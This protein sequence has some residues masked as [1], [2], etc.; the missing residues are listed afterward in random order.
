M[1]PV[2]AV[3]SAEDLQPHQIYDLIVHYRKS[4]NVEKNVKYLTLAAKSAYSHNHVDSAH[5]LL[6]ELVKIGSNGRQ[7]SD[8]ML[9]A[10]TERNEVAPVVTTES[11]S[12]VGTKEKFR[13]LASLSLT[14]D[15]NL[16]SPEKFFKSPS[17]LSPSF[18]TPTTGSSR[19]SAG[20]RT[21]SVLSPDDHAANSRLTAQHSLMSSSPRHSKSMSDPAVYSRNGPRFSP[22]MDTNRSPKLK[23]QLNIRNLPSDLDPYYK[24]KK[25]VVISDLKNKYEANS[26]YICEQAAAENV[27]LLALLTFR[28]G[29]LQLAHNLCLLFIDK[30]SLPMVDL[31]T[32]NSENLDLETMRKLRANSS[33]FNAEAVASLVLDSPVKGQAPNFQSGPMM[34]PI[35]EG[36]TNS[37]SNDGMDDSSSPVSKASNTAKKSKQSLG[38]LKR[39]LMFG[40]KATSELDSFRFSRED[41]G[42]S[43]QSTDSRWK[44]S[45]AVEG[46]PPTPPRPAFVSNIHIS[47][48]RQL[49]ATNPLLFTTYWKAVDRLILVSLMRGHLAVAE[50]LY[51]IFAEQKSNLLSGDSVAEKSSTP[52]STKYSGNSSGER[53]MS[54]I[55]HL[56]TVTLQGNFDGI[57]LKATLSTLLLLAGQ[58]HDARKLIDNAM[59]AVD[60]TQDQYAWASCLF[61]RSLHSASTCDFYDARVDLIGASTSFTVVSDSNNS[62]ASLL[63]RAWCGVL[64]GDGLHEV[65]FFLKSMEGKIAS[66]V[67]I[68]QKNVFLRRSLDADRFRGSALGD[69]VETPKTSPMHREPGTSFTFENTTKSSRRHSVE[70]TASTN[71]NRPSTRMSVK[72][73]DMS[74]ALERLR[75]TASETAHLSTGDA[76]DYG[77]DDGEPVKSP[78]PTP[79]KPGKAPRFT[80]SDRKVQ[81][82]S[83]DVAGGVDIPGGGSLPSH[84]IQWISD[85]AL[86]RCFM[87]RDYNGIRNRNAAIKRRR[88]R[89]LNTY[90]ANVLLA[91]IACREGRLDEAYR[92]TMYAVRLGTARDIVHP[93][94]MY[95][96]FLAGLSAVSTMEA[97]CATYPYISLMI[98]DEDT[99]IGSDEE[100]NEDI[101]DQYF[102]MDG[103]DVLQVTS[104]WRHYRQLRRAALVVIST[105]GK[106]DFCIFPSYMI[107]RYTL[108][109]KK[110]RVENNGSL[111]EFLTTFDRILD[112]TPHQFL[113]GLAYAYEERELLC[114]AIGVESEIKPS[115]TAKRAYPSCLVAK[116]MFDQLSNMKYS[117]ISDVATDEG[118]C[119]NVC[120]FVLV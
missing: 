53:T 15:T 34:S 87:K 96:L 97:L 103:Q 21:N 51:S 95:V 105:L 118:Y 49:S 90:V 44:D 23:R 115:S 32:C 86:I 61:H 64:S 41:L 81:Q 58:Y 89:D 93:T 74:V 27:A 10:M 75:T 73:D 7:L 120:R 84:L 30:L 33:D 70:S 108:I 25:W 11:S 111:R 79:N 29:E 117:D 17:Y 80:W 72:I 6:R 78:V 55:S 104:R 4:D 119:C 54:S 22:V 92:L 71:S 99:E 65:D 28:I 109:A 48:L 101:D 26:E 57:Q 24:T 94:A 59:G 2:S 40:K 31:C 63:L 52:S 13:A 69:S 50:A 1:N 37:R 107:L 68:H 56:T 60:P 43:I 82:S 9:D 66:D 3:R 36:D 85:L 5:L 98:E 14:I 83:D 12:G 62:F 91:N 42:S 16:A 20:A 19:H 47:A 112:D 35:D 39:F 100:E 114:R 8:L 106:L 76:I 67:A 113:M 116:A 46:R 38:N 18:R 88:K 45:T 110:N 77:T 102:Q